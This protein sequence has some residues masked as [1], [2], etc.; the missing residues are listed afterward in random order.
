MF[1]I[2]IIFPSCT[3]TETSK[4]T[5]KDANFVDTASSN[6]DLNTNSEDEDQLPSESETQEDDSGGREEFVLDVC[7]LET[8][9]SLSYELPSSLEEAAQLTL[10][11]GPGESYF[12][13]K[14]SNEDGWFVLEVPSWMCQIQLYSKEEVS[15]TMEAS[16]DWELNDVAFPA[17]EC[18][19]ETLFLHSWTF[20]AWGSYIVHIE[21]ENMTEIW[22]ASA[23][24]IDF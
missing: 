7:D 21:A 8:N 12:L 19:E 17:L 3:F 15:I 22:L 14:Q 9:T 18:N 24:V 10:V 16:E 4:S 13:S 2:T 11:A 6:T 20:H 5:V 1:F 23:M